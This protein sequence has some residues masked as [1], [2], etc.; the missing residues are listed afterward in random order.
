[1]FRCRVPNEIG[2][3]QHPAITGIELGKPLEI[4][5]FFRFP[6]A[7]RKIDQRIWVEVQHRRNRAQSRLVRLPIARFSNRIRA[8]A[9]FLSQFAIGNPQTALRFADDVPGVVFQFDHNLLS[10]DSERVRFSIAAQILNLFADEL[11]ECACNID[12]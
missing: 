2:V 7:L 4:L 11:F 12:N 5:E 6:L 8:H 1:M 3:H 9:R 10:S